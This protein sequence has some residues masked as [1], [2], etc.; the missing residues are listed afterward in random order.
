M[1]IVKIIMIIKINYDYQ[2]VLLRK[3]ESKT[4]KKDKTKNMQYCIKRID[5]ILSIV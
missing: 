4:T 3:N 1:N 2:N 5:K